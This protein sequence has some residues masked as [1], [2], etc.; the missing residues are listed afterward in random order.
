M[1]PDV[2]ASAMGE[3]EAQLRAWLKQSLPHYMMPSRLIRL[4]KL[5]ILPNG[6]L[7]RNALQSSDFVQA[8]VHMSDSSVT[9]VTASPTSQKQTREELQHMLIDAWKDMLKRDHVD[10][11]EH[12]LILAATRWAL[13]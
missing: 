5:P 2:N 12:F 13:F 9:A 1:K 8:A 10:V 6:K 11:H 3:K 4:E 7:N